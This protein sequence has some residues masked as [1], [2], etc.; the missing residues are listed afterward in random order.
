MSDIHRLAKLDGVH[1]QLV[2][3]VTRICAAMNALGVV[4]IVTDAVRTVKQQQALYAQ[5][6]TKPGAIVTQLDGVTKR[7]NHQLHP[8]GFGHAV[9]L[10]FWVD[11]K[12]SWAEV[13]PWD[14]YGC[15]VRQQGMLWGGDWHNPDRPHIEMRKVP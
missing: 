2:T 5:G 15:M 14:L 3:N 13:N 12:P 6:R 1:P 10:C 9:D 11:G 7:S 4:M 8:D